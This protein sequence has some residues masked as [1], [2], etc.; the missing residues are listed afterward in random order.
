MPKKEKEKKTTCRPRVFKLQ[1]VKEKEKIIERRQ[2]EKISYQYRSKDKNY[3]WFLINHA[4]KNRVKYLSGGEKFIVF[5]VSIKY[6]LKMPLL[7][8]LFFMSERLKDM[9]GFYVK[10]NLFPKKKSYL[11]LKYHEGF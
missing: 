6:I 3:I 7:M 4:I 2:R 5:Y 9:T 8:T 1:K 10:L 11:V